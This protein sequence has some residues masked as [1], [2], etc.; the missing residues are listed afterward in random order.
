MRPWH[1]KNANKHADWRRP[2]A[3]RRRDRR[4]PVQDTARDAAAAAYC[5]NC[6]PSP[7]RSA[8]CTADGERYNPR[9]KRTHFFWDL[10]P[11]LA[12]GLL[13]AQVQFIGLRFSLRPLWRRGGIGAPIG[14]PFGAQGYRLQSAV[15][16]AWHRGKGHRRDHIMT[17]LAH[18][19]L[20]GG[21][22][23]LGQ[24]VKSRASDPVAASS[25]GRR[26]EGGGKREEGG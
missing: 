21:I 11:S 6:R 4:G 18:R 26:E 1:S 5:R 14:A 13:Q 8:C 7:L 10:V 9:R 15:A 19:T 22:L 24:R 25:R 12:G 3:P 17:T 2:R 20:A 16:T 23:A